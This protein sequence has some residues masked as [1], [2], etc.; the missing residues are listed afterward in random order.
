VTRT[1]DGVDVFEGAYPYAGMLVTPSWGGSMF[2]ALMPALFVPEERL[3]PQSWGINHPATVR[4]QIYH[5]LNEA[6]YGYW[7]FSPSNT[8]EGGYAAYG[9]DGIGMDPGGNP[10]N[11]DRTLI[12]H[13][14]AGCSG[15]D[16]QPDP[17]PSAYTNGVVTPHAAFLALRFAPD[18]TLAN[19]DK[20]A[21]DF[22]KVYGKWGFRDSVNVGTGAVSNA[23]LSLDQGMIMAALG[24]ALGGDVLRKA[25]TTP[26]VERTLGR[27]IGQEQFGA[28]LG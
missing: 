21:R 26:D 23:Y 22:P 5:G 24:N 4:A 16:A 18:A 12:D 9:V 25:F 20:L 2:E 8:P 1:Y 28:S 3:A 6:Q 17:P 15:R 27:V 13:G 11:E 14:F 19:L 7:G 10:S